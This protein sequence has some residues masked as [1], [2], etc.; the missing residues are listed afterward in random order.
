[1]S[2]CDSTINDASNQL[3]VEHRFLSPSRPA[4]ADW[5]TLTITQASADLHSLGASDPRYL[6]FVA[7]LGSPKCNEAL[8][9]AQRELLLRRPAMIERMQEMAVDGPPP[10]KAQV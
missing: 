4:P 9:S 8:A 1:M 10:S 5:A 3:A 7:Q 6:D 2:S